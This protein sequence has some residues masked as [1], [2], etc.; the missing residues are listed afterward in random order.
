[1]NDNLKCNC[2]SSSLD[3]AVE[4]NQSSSASQKEG[5]G[6]ARGGFQCKKGHLNQCSALSSTGSNT[7]DGPENNLVC[8]TAAEGGHHMKD[9]KHGDDGASL[10]DAAALVPGSPNSCLRAG[11][12]VH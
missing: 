3:H 10:I 6:Q 5:R 9:Y 7:V 4:G 2:P 1:M 12:F 11:C 8:S